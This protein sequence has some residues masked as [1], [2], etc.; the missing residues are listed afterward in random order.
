MKFQRS[1][2]FRQTIKTHFDPEI[3]GLDTFAILF[4]ARQSRNLSMYNNWNFTRTYEWD[5]LTNDSFWYSPDTVMLFETEKF[6]IGSQAV[7]TLVI[8]LEPKSEI[9]KG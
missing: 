8:D 2:S 5:S 6:K 3:N 9:K 7:E 4:Q 1:N